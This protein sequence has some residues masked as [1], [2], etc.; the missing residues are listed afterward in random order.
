MAKVINALCF[1][2]LGVFFCLA[3]QRAVKRRPD[4]A[5]IVVEPP[6]LRVLQALP[7]KDYPR[8]WLLIDGTLPLSSLTLDTTGM[9]VEKPPSKEGY[10]R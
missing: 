9:M 10:T 8:T 3:M 2:C 4:P 1:I 6:P 7:I 5:P